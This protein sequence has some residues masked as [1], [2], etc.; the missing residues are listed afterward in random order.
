MNIHHYPLPML[1]C[2][3]ISYMAAFDMPHHAKTNEIRRWCVKMFG[4]AGY[5][6]ETAESRWTDR[7]KFGEI[8]FQYQEDLAL[9]L[10]RW[11]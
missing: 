5:S 9:F 1:G 8:V 4:Q 11:L 2:S 3:R 7:I 10:L 6:A